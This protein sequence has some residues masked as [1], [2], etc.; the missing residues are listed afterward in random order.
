MIGFEL[1]LAAK[2]LHYVAAGITQF[3]VNGEKHLAPSMFIGILPDEEFGSGTL[4]LSEGD[5]LFFLTDGFTD[6]LTVREGVDWSLPVG[7]NYERGL[8]QLEELASLGQLRDD[9]TALC[10]RINCWQQDHKNKLKE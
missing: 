9:A 4:P 3:Y 8:A 10:I 1:D 6:L 7:R 5:V 2:E